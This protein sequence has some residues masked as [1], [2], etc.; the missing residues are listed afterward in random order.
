MGSTPDR[1]EE[2]V[3]GYPDLGR[4]PDLGATPG[5]SGVPSVGA[6]SFFKAVNQSFSLSLKPE[7][8]V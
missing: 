1:H 8:C 6:V 3:A 4:D 7:D 2:P 5:N